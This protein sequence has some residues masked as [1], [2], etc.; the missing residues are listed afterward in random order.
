MGISV[1]ILVLTIMYRPRKNRTRQEQ[2]F[3]MSIRMKRLY[4]F[5][6]PLLPL[7]KMTAVQVQTQQSVAGLETV[8]TLTTTVIALQRIVPIKTLAIIRIFAGLLQ[9]MVKKSSLIRM[10]E[11]SKICT[12]TDLLGLTMA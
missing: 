11:S 2:K 12:V 5:L 4:P 3:S 6:L 1:T 10:T 7:L 8:N 9:K